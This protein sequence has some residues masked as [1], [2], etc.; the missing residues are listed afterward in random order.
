M[1]NTDHF[2]IVD[3][4][5]RHPGMDVFEELL[6]TN[7]KKYANN[8]I[9]GGTLNYNIE[10][11]STGDYIISL[12][13]NKSE[14]D[15]H[16]ITAAIIERKTWSDLSGSIKDNRMSH[17]LAKMSEMKRTTG[18]LVYY[19]IEGKLGRK[20]KVANVPVANLMAKIRQNTARGY[21][22]FFSTDSVDTMIQIVD[23]ARDIIK[24]YYSGEL[25]FPLQE[26]RTGEEINMSLSLR[27]HLTN[28]KSENPTI[29]NHPLVEQLDTLLDCANTVSGNWEPQAI[30]NTG[31]K[32]INVEVMD[33]IYIDMWKVFPN[34]SITTATALHKDIPISDLMKEDLNLDSIKLESGRK[35]GSKAVIAIMNLRGDP[36]TQAKI[37]ACIPSIT[38]QFAGC[39]LEV[40]DMEQLLEGRFNINLLRILP[41]CGNKN[42]S[43]VNK[44]VKYMCPDYDESTAPQLL[45]TSSNT[46]K[47]LNKFGT[48]D[49]L[50]SNISNVRISIGRAEFEISKKF[51]GM[52]EQFEVGHNVFE[53]WLS[54]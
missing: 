20:K 31:F 28:F 25:T 5:E 19:I 52:P 9:K 8:P 32:N 23:I 7:N 39:F 38:E 13:S 44:I 6:E 46:Y 51:K 30:M 17:Q 50:Y 40:V 10:R 12:R 45:S 33:D 22:H 37:L 47:F 41:L 11:C 15:T 36:R 21:P 4:R 3:D 16:Y 35:I 49:I 53:D 54:L 26:F 2:I 24:L 29:S 18:C 42:P 14:I 34:V 43:K 1:S 48:P 27:N